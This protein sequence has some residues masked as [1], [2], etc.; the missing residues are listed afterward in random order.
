VAKFA[1]VGVWL[2][3]SGFLTPA[4]LGSFRRQGC[5][6]KLDQDQRRIFGRLLV[7]GNIWSAVEYE[8]FE[9]NLEISVS[10]WR[11]SG[12]TL[13]QTNRRALPNPPEQ[14]CAFASALAL[15]CGLSTGEIQSIRVQDLSADGLRVGPGR[16]IGFG[17][18]RDRLLKPLLDRY[19]ELERPT[20]YLLF[21][22]SPRDHKKPISRQTL[23]AAIQ[24]L[25]PE[26]TITSLRKR[27]F[28]EDFDCATS[29]NEFWFHLLN[30]HGMS[31]DHIRRLIWGKSRQKRSPATKGFANEATVF[32]VPAPYLLAAICA[33]CCVP[34]TS[35]L[36]QSGKRRQSK[37]RRLLERYD[38]TIEWPATLFDELNKAGQ[39]A[40]R[41]L[42]L[43]YRLAWE[44]WRNGPKTNVEHKG[45]VGMWEEDRDL[46]DR[47][48]LTDV[49]IVD[50]PTAHDWSGRLFEFK[51]QKRNFTVP[52]IEEMTGGAWGG[53]CRACWHPGREELDREIVA[54]L[55]R[56]EELA[57]QERFVKELTAI[58]ERFRGGLTYQS[59]RGH[60]GLNVPV[61]GRG[62]TQ[63][64]HIARAPAAP[65][66]RCRRDFVVRLASMARL[67]LIFYGLLL[68]SGVEQQEFSVDSISRQLGLVVNDHELS[69][70]LNFLASSD[71][72]IVSS[73]QKTPKGFLVS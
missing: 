63:R 4:W 9:R 36:L 64:I 30:T 1:M 42:R 37:F 23:N 56:K 18:G 57:K 31:E 72:P 45:R 34:S 20:E 44:H 38:V 70:V 21:A 26:A 66:A 68:A 49:R 43:L 12:Q 5:P 60:A 25:R 22:K 19:L 6:T 33:S 14:L 55:D 73:F 54:V 2:L 39:K 27:H 35:K 11:D 47:L 48:A 58:A 10:R 46:V 7:E 24:A 16:N 52:L 51:T 61:H 32:P 17:E 41:A 29:L 50:T 15:G 40:E 28:R 53:K 8:L 67:P 13:V 62:N 69:L 71:R 65:L 3:L 59:L